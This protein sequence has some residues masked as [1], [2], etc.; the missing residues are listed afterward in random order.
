MG[1]RCGVVGLP[2]VGKSTLFNAITGNSVPAE[3]YPFCTVDPNTG[4]VP[5]PDSRLDALVALLSPDKW[6]PSVLEFIDIAGLVKGA[7]NGEGLG[8]QFLSH[9]REVDV[10]AHVVRCFSDPNVAHVSGAVD[11]AG[12]AKTVQTELLLKDLDTLRKRRDKIIN[13]ARSGEKAYKDELEIVDRFVAHADGGTALRSAVKTDSERRISAELGLLTTKP[14]FFVAN[15]GEA[16]PPEEEAALRAL[17]THAAAEGTGLLEIRARFEAELLGL[18]P[19][20]RAAFMADAGM[21]E[22]GLDALVRE[23]Y[24]LLDIITFYTT[25]GTEIRAW[26]VPRGTRAVDA[27]GKIH[28]DMAKGFVKAECIR[29]EDLLACGSEKEARANGKGTVEGKDYVV[30]DGDVLHIRFTPAAAR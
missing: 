21:K 14:A 15:V 1:F 11:P 26:T 28:T 27:A 7:S 29:A 8:N 19:D 23:G 10:I 2:N 12:D 16:R 25:V 9:I 4:V 20:D 6:T 13:H 5:V 30:R 3:N 24:R 17:K 18:G 22:T